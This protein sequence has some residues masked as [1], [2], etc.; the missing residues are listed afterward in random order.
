MVTGEA[1]LSAVHS[2]KVDLAVPLPQSDRRGVSSGAR[3]VNSLER[4]SRLLMAE[5]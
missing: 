4:S 5:P 3:R 2:E 1:S